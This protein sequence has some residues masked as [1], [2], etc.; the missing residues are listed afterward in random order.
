MARRPMHESAGLRVVF[1]TRPDCAHTGDP[2]DAVVLEHLAA[3]GFPGPWRWCLADSLILDR[4]LAFGLP[5]V[6]FARRAAERTAPP[7]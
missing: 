1:C 6:A 7:G 5:C 3:A 4:R 2:V